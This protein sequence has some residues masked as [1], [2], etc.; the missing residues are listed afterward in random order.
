MKHKASITL[1]LLS[2]F[3]ITQLIGIYTIT[4]YAPSIEETF[5]ETTQ[6]NQ[7]E[8]TQQELPFGLDTQGQTLSPISIIFSLILA[9]IIFS[10]LM[11]HD[12]KWIMK[13]WFSLVIVIALGITLYPSL[14]KYTAYPTLIALLISLPLAYFK[15]IKPRM[16]VHNITELFIYPGIAIVIIAL[17]Y[18]P[19]NPTYSIIFMLVL[20]FLISIY[21]AWAVWHSGIMQKMAKYQMEE[22]KVFG[23]FLIPSIS[24]KDKE[25]IN[26][27]KLK[28]KGKK[29]PTKETKK[30]YKIN[31]AILG[32]GDVIFPIITAG[33]F[34]W[35]YSSQSL[36]GIPGLIPGLFIIAGALA[37]LS[38]LFLQTEKGKAYPAMPYITAGI[39]A[40][41]ILWKIF[42]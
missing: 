20:L 39:Y 13:A 23:G 42:F 38:Y 32:G 26:A 27:L 34:M 28:Y 33:V 18:N 4:A 21:D 10:L 15:I 19:L 31:L 17:I 30:K 1:L 3:L 11:K 8:I 41:L 24:K 37:G 29:I 25:K 2:M 22:L 6:E 16:L 40:G 14:E 7:F 12:L 35:T 5:N 9:I 36:F